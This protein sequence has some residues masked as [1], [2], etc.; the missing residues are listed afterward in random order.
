MRYHRDF[1][2]SER[3]SGQSEIWLHYE[4]A[5]ALAPQVG[6]AARRALWACGVLL[7]REYQRVVPSNRV[8][9]SVAFDVKP[10]RMYVGPRDYRA[11]FLEAGAKSHRIESRGIR[12]KKMRRKYATIIVGFQ[13]GIRYLA[14]PSGGG[15]VF[16]SAANHPGMSAGHYLKRTGEGNV[17]MVEEIVARAFQDAL[18]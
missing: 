17:G 1:F 10:P 14:I 6:Y 8:K 7:G 15:V 12:L 11:N 3:I 5:V 13:K 9:R 2:A 16:R 4:A 18:R